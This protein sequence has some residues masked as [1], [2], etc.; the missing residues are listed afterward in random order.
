MKRPQP[1]RVAY[2]NARLL[3]PASGLDSPGGLLTDGP[4]IADF[5]P[6]LFAD[7]VPEGA[8]VVDC[9]GHCLCPGLVDIR[10]HLREPG[11]EHKETLASASQA[12]AAGGITSIACMPNT[13]PVIDQIPMVEFIARRARETSEV[14]IYPCAAITVGLQGEHLTEIGM[15]AEAD[16]TGFTDADRAVMN[17]KVMR[18][19]LSYASAFDVLIMQHPEDRA[20]AE[21]GTMNEGELATRL[22]LA[23]VPIAAETILIERDL[24]L[25]ETVPRG[26]YHVA[27]LSSGA[28]VDII[29][30]AKAR[31]LPVSCA[32]APHYFA[33]NETAV[34]D[35]LT[36]AKVSP[37]LRA[38]SDRQ[39]VAAGIAEGVIDVIVSDH[40]PHDQDSKRVPF[41][42]A[43]NGI[44]GV[45]TML[46]LALELYHKG[47]VP[48]LD[49]LRTMTVRPAELLKLPGGRLA[50]GAHADLC[51]FDLDAPWTVD[52]TKLRSKSKNAPYDGRPLQG[53]VLRTV[54]D[55]RTIFEAE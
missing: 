40:A 43:A 5:G 18:R 19:A 22:G 10:A 28:S 52:V 47:D 35:Y 16:V 50:A 27:H 32:T 36:F 29:R 7:G 2:V 31:G 23:G 17:S 3:D 45:E 15:L 9:E 26:R 25:L 24:R 21:D 33:L 42:Q 55:G 13:D 30:A 20:L 54:V 12:A 8:A 38:E 51:L 14:K 41:A 34:G 4:L 48:L 46:P 1:G 11:A 37:P 6:R 39:A 53:R 44:I 49:L